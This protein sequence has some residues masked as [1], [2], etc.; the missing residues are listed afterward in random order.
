MFQTNI[1]QVLGY[2]FP[3]IISFLWD[4]VKKQIDYW[5]RILKYQKQIQFLGQNMRL[6]LP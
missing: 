1:R 6:F 3:Q 2:L 5:V 4:I